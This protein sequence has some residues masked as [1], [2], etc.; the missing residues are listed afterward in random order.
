MLYVVPWR[1]IGFLWY[2][3]SYKLQ[4]GL[5]RLEFG[6][7]SALFKSQKSSDGNWNPSQ[8]SFSRYV[9]N[10]NFDMAVL[11]EIVQRSDNNIQELTQPPE[12]RGKYYKLY[13]W[14]M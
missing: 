12:P 4:R 11:L 1:Y 10:E 7:F 5:N 8:S 14:Y 13:L 6:N 9:S 2:E 3:W